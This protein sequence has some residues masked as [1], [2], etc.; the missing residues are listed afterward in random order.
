MLS[1]Q[2]GSCRWHLINPTL[3]VVIGTCSTLDL[4]SAEEE[5]TCGWDEREAR[6]REKEECHSHPIRLGV[7]LLANQSVSP[8]S[9]IFQKIPPR[10]VNSVLYG[11]YRNPCSLS[12]LTSFLPGTCQIDRRAKKKPILPPSNLWR[13]ILDLIYIYIYLLLLGPENVSFHIYIS[14]LVNVY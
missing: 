11:I 6:R 2:S 13:D 4:P 12:A 7:C 9:L 14:T 3:V 8:F 5:K 1:W 10:L